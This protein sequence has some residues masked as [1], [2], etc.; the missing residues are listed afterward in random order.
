M[1]SFNLG[2]VKG[3]KGDRGATGAK[4]DTGAKG[5]KGD[6]GDNGRD[7]L[8]PVFT[9]GGT[10]TLTPGEKAYVEINTENPAEPVLYFRIPA[11]FD[12]KDAMGDMLSAVYDTEGVK[13]DVYKYA[14][15]LF[16]GCLKVTGG[17][18]GGALKTSETSLAEGAVRNISARKTFPETAAEGDFCIIMENSDSKKIGD[19][20]EGDIFLIE[21]SGEEKP[22]IVVAKD[23]HKEGSVTLLRQNLIDTK[24]KFSFTKRGYYPMCEADIFLEA[25]FKP[26][27]TEK[28]KENLIAAEVETETYRHCFILSKDEITKM[29]YLSTE[30]GRVARRENETYTERYITRSINS[31]GSIITVSGSGNFASAEYSAETFYRPAV[32]V[33]SDLKVI[34]TSYKNE[35]A[36]KL[37]EI[38][39][40]LYVY[41][42]GEWKECAS[43]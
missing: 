42:G 12:G 24:G 7:G 25:M 18:V 2:R 32:V 28:I 35:P 14:R 26:I 36:V 39:C 41:I 13:A 43:L 5:E 31:Q 11:G 27:L 33:K 23:Y 19:C 16:D 1:G 4:G 6:K 38:K 21:E 34:N 20:N 30:S 15:D 8:T 40:G 37:D 10:A 29:N 9:V 22:Y 3:D 17:T